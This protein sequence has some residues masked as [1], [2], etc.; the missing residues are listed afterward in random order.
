MSKKGKRLEKDN[1]ALRRQKDA[2]STNII[3]MAEERQELKKRAE[4]AEKKSNVL[5]R[6]IA[7]MQ[8]QGRKLPP[9]MAAVV[10]SY[11]N[12]AAEDG[13]ESAYSNEELSDFE[14][15]DD[16]TDEE[17]PEQ[18]VPYGPERPPVPP[19]TAP[20]INGH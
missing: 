19:Q 10:D 14:E 2:T 20:A 16:V 18:P 7:Q 4:V 8:E 12:P 15:D 9:G 13:D 5:T 1:D 17:Q 6:T 11:L 3:R